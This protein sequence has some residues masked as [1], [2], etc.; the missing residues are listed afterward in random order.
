MTIHTGQTYPTGPYEYETREFVFIQEPTAG[1]IAGLV[2]DNNLSSYV[3]TIDKE[4]VEPSRT[5]ATYNTHRWVVK[6]RKKVN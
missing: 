2:W 5:L 6:F 3:L 1:Q 4:Y